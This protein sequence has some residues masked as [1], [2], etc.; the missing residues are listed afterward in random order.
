ML[1]NY[2]LVAWR[3]LTKHR[4]NA[5]I[6]VLGLSVA[7]ACSMLLFLMVH[8]EFSFDGFQKFE[9]SLFELYV[10]SRTPGGDGKST[11]MAY[12]LVS[13]LKSEAP[14]ISKATGFMSA[15]SGI[16]YKNKELD[17]DVTLVNND[18]FSM[19]SFPVLSGQKANPLAGTGE[20]VISKSTAD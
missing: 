20:V 19:F 3:N 1:R 16:R 9:P 2:F 15:G 14:A 18:F 11:S 17:K 7:F 12:P 8:R 4:L 10:L 6:N 5:G 13:V